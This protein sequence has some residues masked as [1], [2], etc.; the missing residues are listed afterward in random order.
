MA[1]IA[2]FWVRGVLDGPREVAVEGQQDR[3]TRLPSVVHVLALGTLLMIMATPSDG[4]GGRGVHDVDTAEERAME[5][6]T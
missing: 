6:G 1:A 2:V 3:R 4:A 5:V